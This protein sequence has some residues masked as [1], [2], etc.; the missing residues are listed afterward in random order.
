MAEK[1][2]KVYKGKQKL[3]HWCNKSSS[4]KIK[5]KKITHYGKE[6]GIQRSVVGCYFYPAFYTYSLRNYLP[7]NKHCLSREQTNK[8]KI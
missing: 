8:Q 2:P 3:V 7:V 1:I 4:Q 6:G 5:N